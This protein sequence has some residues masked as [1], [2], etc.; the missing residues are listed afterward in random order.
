VK[1]TRAHDV[2]VSQRNR[3]IGGLGLRS[4]GRGSYH[5]ATEGGC[6]QREPM[7]QHTYG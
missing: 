3:E 7:W 5:L 6:I 2:N 4:V 1:L